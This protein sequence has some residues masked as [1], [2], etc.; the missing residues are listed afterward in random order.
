MK[1][2]LRTFLAKVAV[3]ALIV[4]ATATAKGQ[5]GYKVT[6][7]TEAGVIAV[8]VGVGVGVGVGIY[9]AVHHGHALTGCAVSG[10]NGLQLQSDQQTYALI[11]NVAA[12]KPGD[13][14][15]VAGKKEKTNAGGS[16]QFLVERVAK[17][18]GVCTVVPVTR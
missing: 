15:R 18:Y 13:R 10:S 14:V 8:L 1:T 3:C 16:E 9:F 5:F 6:K 4:T 12:I 17:D 11:G 7:G 2:G